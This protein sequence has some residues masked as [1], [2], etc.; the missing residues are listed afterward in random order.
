MTH[1]MQQQPGGDEAARRNGVLPAWIVAEQVHRN[2]TPRPRPALPLRLRATLEALATIGRPTGDGGLIVTPGALWQTIGLGH[3]TW[4]RH[5]AELQQRGYLLRGPTTG[6]R[7][8]TY[9]IPGRPPGDPNAL[10]PGTAFSDQ[11][12]AISLG[13]PA[14]G[15]AH[16]TDSP[17]M[18]RVPKWDESQ[19]GTVRPA[20]GRRERPPRARQR[21]RESQNGTLPPSP[22][23]PLPLGACAKHQKRG[24]ERGG[25]R[26]AVSREPRAVSQNGR[27]AP[28]TGRGRLQLK[29]ED[30][31]DTRKLV[32]VFEL[33]CRKHWLLDNEHDWLEL[34]A[35]A[36]YARK[37]A[38]TSPVGYLLNLL[39][40]P[41]LFPLPE[42]A[43]DEAA[44]MRRYARGERPVRRSAIDEVFEDDAVED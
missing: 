20:G 34:L 18:G 36:A 37:Q 3:G 14:V 35:R 38:S 23:T 28:A 11:Q 13:S 17:K 41:P 10:L 30:L 5:L 31:A 29:P 15:R 24:G 4:W 25:E 1:A 32:P 19:N 44:R 40:Q 42:W 26:A 12:S 16:P 43:Y 21:R 33:A 2:G 9:Q 22:H 27:A 6:R 8:T 39:R 7:P